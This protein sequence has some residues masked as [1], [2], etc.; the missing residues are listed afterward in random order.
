MDGTLVDTEP[1]WMAVET[2]LVESHGGTWGHEQAMQLVGKGLMDSATIL[3][4][5]GVDL[6]PEAIVQLLTDEVSKTLRTR[7]VPFRPGA[8]E[9]LRGLR[10]A[11]IPTG[12]VTMSLRRMA[13]G[14][15]DL[16][17]FPAFDVVVAGDEVEHPKPHPRP[18]LR[19][20]ELLGID[21]ADALVIEDSPTGLGAGI[22]SGA[23]TLGV[24]HM[25]SLDGLGAHALWPT[26]EGR[27]VDDLVDLFAASTSRAG[28]IR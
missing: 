11:G 4:D 5:A 28:A 22:A 12:L 13:D 6:A 7:G 9:L 20:A 3:R 2:T 23:V 16:I 15:V 14:V 18:Y 26:L 1:Y 25:V 10:D 8:R 19:G 24:P 17:D 21:I 27:T